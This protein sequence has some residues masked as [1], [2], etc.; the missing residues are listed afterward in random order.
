[1]L[2]DKKYR[3]IL[4]LNGSLPSRDFFTGA[5][6]LIAADG[7]AN[8]LAAMNILPHMIIGDLDSVD[9]ALLKTCEH[10][11]DAD[12]GSSDFQKCLAYMQDNILLPSIIVGVNG[13]YLDHVL[14]NIN[15]FLQTD[16]IFYAP[17]MIG[18]TIKSGESHHL[19]LAAGTKISLLGLPQATVTTRGLKWELDAQV[20]S[21][22][23]SNSC[24]NRAQHDEVMIAADSGDV[25]VLVYELTMNDAGWQPMF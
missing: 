18:F 14:N 4:C 16:S 15:I 19:K 24:F 25:L 1:M 21:F 8:K 12:Q 9:A 11:H 6:P 22:P 7:A 20:L 13:G 10:I 3:S 2:T 5:L 23:G 17:P